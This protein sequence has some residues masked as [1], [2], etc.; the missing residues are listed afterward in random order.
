MELVI[1]EK[2]SQ[3][4]DIAKVIGARKRG[5]GFLE[6]PDYVVTWCIGHL[7]SLAPMDT[8]DPGLKEWSLEALPFMPTEFKLTPLKG[9]GT[10]WR[11]VNQVLRSE[12]FSAVI[13]ATDAGR[14]GELIFDLVY[15]LSGSRIPV[16]RLWTASLTPDSIRQA[17]SQI[18]PSEHH[19]GLADAARS[20][21]EA[22]WIVGLN[23]TRAQTLV[24]RS[25]GHSGVF[26]V[27]RVQTPTLALLVRRENEIKTFRKEIFFTILTKLQTTSGSFIG[28]WFKKNG[29]QI[30]TRI[31]TKEDASDPLKK[32]G[33]SGT[34][35]KIEKKEEKRKAPLLYD[36]TSLQKEAN[37]RFSFTAEYT[38]KNAQSLYESHKVLS[39][40]RTNSR[41]LTASDSNNLNQ[42]MS[43]KLSE[44]P[45]YSEY[46]KRAVKSI[47]GRYI[48]ENKVEDHHAIIPTSQYSENLSPDEKN[49]FDL[50]VRRIIAAY[51]PDK[52]SLISKVVTEIEEESFY[53]SGRILKDRGWTEVDPPANEK[54]DIL[55]PEL[56]EGEHTRTIGKKIRG[57]ETRPPARFTEAT[58]LGA[59]QTAGKSIE[60]EDLAEAVKDTG[61]GTPATRAAIIENLKKRK[62]IEAK[63]KSLLPTITG[64]KLISMIPTESLKNA[65]LTG[66]W[67]KKLL[68]MEK[69]KYSR[70][71]FMEEIK[72]FTKNVCSDIK[73][74]Y[75]HEYK[76]SQAKFVGP[77]PKCNEHLFLRHWNN[78]FYIKC[79]GRDC[80]LTYAASDCGQPLG[81]KCRSCQGPV[82]LTKNGGRVCAICSEWQQEKKLMMPCLKCSSA[83]YSLREYKGK[84]Y[85]RC[86]NDDCKDSFPTDKNGVPQMSCKSCKSPMRVTKSGSAVCV[87]CGLWNNPLKGSKKK[88]KTTGIRC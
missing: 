82:N 27:G 34:I 12:R 2:P 26:S 31:R 44:H 45:D 10:Q 5:D 70:V 56:S 28:Q 40:P 1:C 83:S 19:N 22:D 33:D 74:S 23:A 3:A 52:I 69:G 81:G 65:E 36:L 15:R 6:G 60:N 18:K 4:R 7:V 72:T 39:Y 76:G 59:M 58:L 13:N 16:K 24:A 25:C 67:E 57:G 75:N 66:S 71:Q 53:T 42:I 38:L 8:Y 84:H 50:V 73:R 47:P 80:S 32:I 14:E 54:K 48:N 88:S 77:C 61:L 35:T 30:I 78:G 86:M 85:A 55:L 51:F 63:D 9:S 46:V 87:N 68:D 79:K 41:Y 29:D 21:A 37:I 62:F 64:E 11:I 17:W 49:I 43:E 20:R